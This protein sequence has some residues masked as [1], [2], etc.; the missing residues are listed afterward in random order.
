MSGGREIEVLNMMVSLMTSSKFMLLGLYDDCFPLVNFLKYSFHEELKIRDP[1]VEKA[2]LDSGLPDDV[3]LTKWFIGMFTGVLPKLY[4]AR[5]I[6]FVLAND[7]TA[8][9]SYTVAVVISLRFHI[10]DKDLD[11][12]NELVNNL[13][14]KA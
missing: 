13:H 6:D 11:Y 9:V 10:I 12:I 1:K 4:A 8:I 2:I 14:G 7:L 5:A 3:W